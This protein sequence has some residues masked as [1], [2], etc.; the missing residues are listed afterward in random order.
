MKYC[1]K[2]FFKIAPMSDQE[3]II[4]KKL[5]NLHDILS[6]IIPI[7]DHPF[8]FYK[9]K[10]FSIIS[11]I[12]LQIDS[13]I[14]EKC[15]LEQEILEHKERIILYSKQLSLPIIDVPNIY[16]LN[17]LKEFLLNEL[18]RIC[19]VRNKVEAEIS[20]TI[21]N[22]LETRDCLGFEKDHKNEY[23][24]NINKENSNNSNKNNNIEGINNIIEDNVS[25]EN[26]SQ[27]DRKNIAHENNLSLCNGLKD[28]DE[29]P[30]LSLDY[31]T[32]LDTEDYTA[33]YIYS[34]ND[35]N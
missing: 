15:Y 23:N 28:C 33:K 13:S 35:I 22:I 7:E 2:Y 20:T 12:D 14:N 19:A 27:N 5:Q 30:I 10:V 16:N 21:S 29:S 9:D 25:I 17:L 31:N 6:D 3:Q 4:N 24:Y 18:K 11:Q 34:N 26:Y 8:S 1:Y 32:I